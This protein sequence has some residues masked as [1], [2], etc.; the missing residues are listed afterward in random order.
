MINERKIRLRTPLG[1]DVL[2]LEHLRGS[3]NLSG[4]FEYRIS[5]L[6]HH[7]S[8]D[9]SAL[10]GQTAT[11]EIELH[12][13]GT[14]YFDGFVVSF[15]HAGSSGA[16]ARYDLVLRPWFWLLSLNTNCRIFQN[17]TVPDI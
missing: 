2:L 7:G 13:G 11:V 1:E 14:R 12:E 17:K 3:E 10:L 9:L 8:L 15:S 16:Y 4:A 5:A 6:S